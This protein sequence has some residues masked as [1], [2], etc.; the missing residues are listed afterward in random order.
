MQDAEENT[1]EPLD[2]LGEAEKAIKLFEKELELKNLSVV[3]AQG[4][5]NKRK[6]TQVG[7]DQ[8]TTSSVCLSSSLLPIPNFQLCRVREI[9]PRPK[10]LRYIKPL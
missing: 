2:N 9:S 6:L 7:L 10:V 8:A 1:W 5:Q 4:Q 3:K